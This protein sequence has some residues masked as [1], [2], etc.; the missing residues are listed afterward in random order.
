MWWLWARGTVRPHIVWFGEMPLLMPEIEAAL[1]EAGL[2]VA[3]GTS[4]QVYPAA[5]FVDLARKSG[6]R[7]MEVN[8]EQT[9]ASG[10]FHE[11]LIGSAGKV[12]PELV[13]RLLIG[14]NA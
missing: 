11:C 14:Q 6:A 1:L 13:E 7:T 8:L 10:A 12:V 9:G 2:F 5:G 3:I 4:G